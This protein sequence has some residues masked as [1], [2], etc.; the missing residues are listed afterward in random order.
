[1]ISYSSG[2]EIHWQ[3]LR[4]NLQVTFYSYDLLRSYVYTLYCCSCQLPAWT[5]PCYGTQRHYSHLQTLRE[6]AVSRYT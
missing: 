1:M 3:F 6:K 5:L 2:T 4:P